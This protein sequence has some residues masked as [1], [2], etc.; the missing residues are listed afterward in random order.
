MRHLVKRLAQ[1]HVVVWALAYA[2]AHDGGGGYAH[3][4]VHNG[5]AKLAADVLS[6]LDKILGLAHYLVIYV[7]AEGVNGGG[8]CA[9][10][11]ADTHRYCAD[12]QVFL[13][14]HLVRLDDL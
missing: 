1:L 14:D 13:V 11:Q 10:Q 6:G 5:Y 7:A 8:P 3:A 4:L 12:I 2:A 9:V